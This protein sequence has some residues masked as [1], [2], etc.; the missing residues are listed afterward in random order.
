MLLMLCQCG[1]RQTRPLYVAILDAQRLIQ[2]TQGLESCEYLAVGA[3]WSISRW[4][5]ACSTGSYVDALGVAWPLRGCGG[6]S[7]LH[8]FGPK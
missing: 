2:G 7:G 3:R 8:H 5:L 1:A 6:V 4:V